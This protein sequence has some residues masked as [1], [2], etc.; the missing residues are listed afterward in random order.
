M[1]A[2]EVEGITFERYFGEE[3]IAWLENL[4]N[5]WGGEEDGY[6]PFT[7][8]DD[9][10][11]FCARLAQN[12]LD[13]EPRSFEWL[14]EHNDRLFRHHAEDPTFRRVV[15]MGLEYG[16]ARE[17]GPCANYLGALHVLGTMVPQDYRRAVELYEIG[18]RKG[19][20]QSAVNLG[21][22]YE[23]G[24]L[25]EPD[26]VRAFMQ[27]AKCASLGE[28][29]EALY[30]LGDMYARAKVV[31]QDLRVAF[32]LWEKSF[33]KAG[34]DLAIKAQGAFRMAQLMEDPANQEWD[35]RYDPMRAF[36]LYQLAERGL[37]ID[38]AHGQAYYRKRLREAIEGQER[39]RAMLESGE[40][41][42]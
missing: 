35:I 4:A 12:I 9:L 42:L 2:D 33:E 6:R 22:A 16:A 34:D 7:D 32:L 36:E 41:E 15:L 10:A 8:D 21:Y 38:I 24:W 29:A 28:H 3:D 37:R 31:R 19:V 23:Y 5:Y 39:I 26:Y 1:G 17:D 20:A 30:K 18:E 25:G 40:I 27:Y 13:D 14:L 11:C